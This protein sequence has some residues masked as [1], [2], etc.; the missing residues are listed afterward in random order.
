MEKKPEFTFDDDED[1]SKYE[2]DS[3]TDRSDVADLPGDD[4]NNNNNDED[5]FVSQ[6]Q[7]PQSFR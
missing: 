2:N 4:D 7:W 3:E 6:V 1:S 5:T